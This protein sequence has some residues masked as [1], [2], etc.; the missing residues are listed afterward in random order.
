MNNIKQS[1]T[2]AAKRNL[3]DIESII[4]ANKENIDNLYKSA[5]IN[6]FFNNDKLINTHKYF[7]NLYN[8]YSKSNI[9]INTQDFNPLSLDNNLIDV[10][11][12][13]DGL[14]PSTIKHSVVGK[15]FNKFNKV[16]T[17]NFSFQTNKP[18]NIS[19][20]YYYNDNYSNINRIIENVT[21]RLYILIEYNIN[22]DIMDKVANITDS[23]EV[24]FFAYPVNRQVK[25]YDKH[26]SEIELDR[27][28]SILS[29]HG[30]YNCSSGYTQ[31]F[32]ISYDQ[33]NRMT[34]SKIPEM[35]GLLTHE[36]GH[37]MGWDFST[38]KCTK[39]EHYPDLKHF[40]LTS[41]QKNKLGNICVDDRQD[42][43][44]F[45]V[46]DNTNTT[47]IHTI[48]NSIEFNFIELNFGDFCLKNKNQSFNLFKEMYY[49]ELLYSIYHSAKILY[50]FGF[51]CFNDFFSKCKN[52]TKYYQ[53]ARLFEYS[54]ARSFMLMKYSSIFDDCIIYDDINKRSTFR[55][56][57]ENINNITDMVINLMVNADLDNNDKELRRNYE[58]VF[59]DF[60]DYLEEHNNLNMEYFCI[61]Y[62][63]INEDYDINQYGG[64]MY[65]HKYAK[66]KKKY[67][68][69]KSKYLL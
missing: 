19:A 33:K 54:I 3:D 53:K 11:S 14:C 68:D 43:Y 17:H 62:V 66:Y 48:C 34:V 69:M 22:D 12:T 8:N 4:S 50:W 31:F 41:E 38:M 10:I 16:Q 65:Y 2:V 42:F 47:I 51:N 9:D 40:V 60:M 44:F 64:N 27:E 52:V 28:M 1:L 15:E 26:S 61:D 49:T 5:N 63:M 6:A 18:F 39:N 24:Y 67:L 20:K 36:I 23:F 57:P 13:I 32:N 30:C 58:K 21:R 55:V 35:L 7:Y 25:G 59:N 46:F 37:L 56:L 45:E 29:N